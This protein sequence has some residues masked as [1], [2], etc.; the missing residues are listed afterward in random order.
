[1]SVTMYEIDDGPDD[2]ASVAIWTASC[3]L[4]PRDLSFKSRAKVGVSSLWVSVTLHSLVLQ[5]GPEL[6]L[7]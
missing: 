4:I 3:G 2:V 5:Q 7:L 6:C 1:M